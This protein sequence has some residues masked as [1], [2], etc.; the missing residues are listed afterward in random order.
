[1][2]KIK[3]FHLFFSFLFF[4]DFFFTIRV[5]GNQIIFRIVYEEK[6]THTLSELLVT[7]ENLSH[8]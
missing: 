7:Y 3:C 1:M 5:Q 4:L 2:K 8:S 6:K